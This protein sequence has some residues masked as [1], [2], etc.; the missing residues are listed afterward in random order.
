MNIRP[1]G[2]RWI[3]FSKACWNAP[4]AWTETS[5]SY[6]VCRDVNT[7]TGIERC[8]MYRSRFRTFQSFLNPRAH[9]A[10]IT[11]TTLWSFRSF[12]SNTQSFFILSTIIEQW[13]YETKSFHTE[14]LH[15]SKMKYPFWT[16]PYQLWLQFTHNSKI[17][18][19]KVTKSFI[20]YQ[21]DLSQKIDNGAQG[22]RIG[23]QGNRIGVAP[24]LQGE[25]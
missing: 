19:P 14:F 16:Y 17:C 1:S 4:P 18:V 10:H 15:I 23:A 8:F 9:S 25:T 13:K 7:Y 6:S 22:N 2:G 24:F 11:W 3:D 20:L 21:K 5:Y 12:S